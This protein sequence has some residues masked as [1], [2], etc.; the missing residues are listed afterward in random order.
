MRPNTKTL[1]TAVLL[2]AALAVIGA[3]PAGAQVNQTFTF[4]NGDLQGWTPVDVTQQPLHFSLQPGNGS[5]V[6]WCGE[7]FGTAADPNPGYGNLWEQYLTKEFTLPAGAIMEYELQYDTE[8]MCDFVYVEVSTDGG[9]NYD[10]P[11]AAYDDDSNGFHTYSTDLSAYGGMTVTIRFRFSSDSGWSDEDGIWDTDGAYRLDEVR[12]DG[13][14]VD[15]FDAGFDGWALSSQGHGGAFRLEDNPQCAPGVS[16][17]PGEWPYTSSWVA[18]DEATG[19]FPFGPYSWGGRQIAIESPKFTINP[20]EATGY[21]LDFYAYVDLPMGCGV[22]IT[23]WIACPAPEDGGTWQ[24]APY[25]YYGTY[26]NRQ[27]H[28]QIPWDYIDPNAT[29]VQIRLGAVAM[30]YFGALWSSTPGPFLDGIT[31]IEE[32]TAVQPGAVAGTVTGDDPSP[33]TPMNG[34]RVNVYDTGGNTVGTTFTDEFGNYEVSDL[35]PADYTVSVVAPLGYT[36]N[37]EALATVASGETLTSD[38]AF[39]NQVLVDCARGIGYWKH[40]VKVATP[41]DVLSKVITM[42]QAKSGKLPEGSSPLCDYLDLIETHFNGNLVNEVAIYVPP[43]SGECSDKVAVAGELLNLHGAQEMAARARQHL[44]A[45]LLNVASNCLPLNKVISDDGAVVSQAITYCDNQID[46]GT[47]LE[48]AK[49]IAE[50]I[51]DGEMVPA[52]WIP[53]ETAIIF[54]DHDVPIRPAGPF[55]AQNHPNPFRSSTAISFRLPEPGDYTLAVFDVAGRL[56]RRYEGY[57]SAGETTVSWDGRDA[58]GQ[59]VAPGIYYY[60]VTSTGFEETRKALVMR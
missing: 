15:T 4:D 34:V 7:D 51:N 27:Y 29:S 35:D 46:E 52:G 53:L 30:W 38:F 33:G 57:G 18:Y 60:R 2:C 54:Y 11:L 16:C 3:I 5:G 45:V 40:Q 21:D 19:Y 43:A 56:V 13:L 55:L 58:A 36:G 50:H 9:A 12:I 48:L 32:G 20:L 37:T 42:N 23:Y 39:T 47:N 25:V 49:D 1:V 8:P 22:Y 44:M 6:V 10:T 41:D 14:T 59:A 31:F 17:L 26:G 24:Q 28:L